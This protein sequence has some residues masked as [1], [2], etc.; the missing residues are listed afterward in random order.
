MEAGPG[1]RR[2]LQIG[3][4]MVLSGAKN[5]GKRRALTLGCAASLLF[6][7][8][9]HSYNPGGPPAGNRAAAVPARLIQLAWRC[10]LTW[11]EQLCRAPISLSF[12]ESVV[13]A[14][15]GLSEAWGLNGCC[16]SV[17]RSGDTAFMII[18][19]SAR[20]WSSHPSAPGKLQ[21][22]VGADPVIGV[23]AEKGLLARLG[24]LWTCPAHPA[25]VLHKADRL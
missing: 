17:N 16:W 18:A 15:H 20:S 5:F 4:V 1:P 19:S 14:D 12:A 23:H 3:G 13:E 11:C 21:P 24:E 10:C 8:D 9:A 22:S 25:T 2:H 7:P 6:A